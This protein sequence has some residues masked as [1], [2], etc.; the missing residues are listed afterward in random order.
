MLDIALK[1]V[2]R[3]KARSFLTVLGIAMGIG[4]IIALGSIGEGLN[5][6]IEES[7]GNIAGVIDVRATDNDEGIS[8][9][10]IDGIKLIEGV[11]SVVPVGTYSIRRGGM[12][13]GF[14]GGGPMMSGGG[15]SSMEFTGV[16]P[17]DLD[18]LVGEEIIAEEGRKLE[19]ADEGEYVVLLG[20]S[21]A[22]NQDLNQG[23]EIEYEREE[24]DTTEIFYFDVIGILEETG[25]DDIDG[26]AYVPL[27]TMQELE[28]D[29][30]INELKVK[31]TNVDLVEEI[32]NEINDEFDEVRAM[33]MLSMVRQM[34]STLGTVTMAVYGI[35]AISVIVGGIGIMNTMI[36]SVMER[37]REIGI[38]KAI[39]ATT[40]M[41]L[42]Q[43]IQE[44][45]MLSVIGGGVGLGLGYFAT[46]LITSYTTFTTIITP[47]LIALGMGFALILGIGAGL[48]PAW[49][50]SRLDPVE[51]L[52]YE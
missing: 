9:D 4:L 19:E 29:D 47:N 38:M 35:G 49:A 34:E 50:A 32:E 48:Y 12:M 37:R 7:F 16:D 25:D 6:Q 52:R 23:D 22:E 43:V 18:L 28:D 3:Q 51:V 24:N 40:T 36:M 26:A 33:S 15:G 46:T 14:R 31:I 45:A 42:K 13:G 20:A 27:K 11:E 8:E 41:I 2:F 1:N 10:V 30:T 21:T 39:G 17:E 5:N 44:S